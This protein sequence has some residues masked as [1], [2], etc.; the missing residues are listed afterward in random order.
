[1]ELGGS[2][3]LASINYERAFYTSSFTEL[4]FRAGF[5]FA[6][7]DRNNGTALIFP[8]MVHALLGEGQHKLDIAAGQTFSITTAGNF[9]IRMPLGLGY[10][11]QPSE[12]PF[13]FR[14][15]YTPIV[16][17]LLD[18]QWEHWAGITFGYQINRNP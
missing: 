2:G 12:K 14:A 1:M 16:S 3:G 10:R 11:Y 8:L 5:S 17:Y 7:I 9:F 4:D 6:P 15:S 18:L 13:Y